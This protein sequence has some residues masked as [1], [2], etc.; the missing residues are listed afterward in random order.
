MSR[1]VRPATNEDLEACL[2]M[3]GDCSTDHVWQLAQKDHPD[4]IVAIFSDVRLPRET[5]AEYPHRPAD[6]IQIWKSIDA[7][8]VAEMHGTL[9]GFIDVRAEPWHGTAWVS[10]LIVDLP[11]RRRGI[12]T[13]LVQAASQWA[14]AHH[15]TAL[16]VETQAQNWPSVRFYQK[17]GFSFAGF[18]DH[19]YTNQIAIFFARP[20]R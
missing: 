11:Y 12:G 13:D 1:I 6:I 18:S 10:N 9:C 8:L 7:L 14:I 4:Q 3:N 20:A 17:L 15:L 19:Y 16:M 2:Q 5:T